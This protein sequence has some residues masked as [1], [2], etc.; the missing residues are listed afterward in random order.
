MADSVPAWRSDVNGA[1][2]TKTVPRHLQQSG[3]SVLGTGTIYENPARQHEQY[4]AQQQEQ[5]ARPTPLYPG[6]P[7]L[8]SSQQQLQR[9]QRSQ[10]QS[11][12]Q[13][14]RS[15]ASTT[16][17]RT[18]LPAPVAQRDG[19]SRFSKSASFAN[20]AAAAASAI[21]SAPLSSPVRGGTSSKARPFAY[22]HLASPTAVHDP[23]LPRPIV[24]VHGTVQT[25]TQ[26]YVERKHRGMSRNVLGGY[27]TS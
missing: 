23:E 27:Y 26:R 10:S 22:G 21:P 5:A 11:F 7:G 25:G 6:L 13:S 2:G 24:V 8:R 12:S 19:T 20:G 4:Q 3:A 9:T 18:P 17:S 15:Y 1:G 16:R 14:Q